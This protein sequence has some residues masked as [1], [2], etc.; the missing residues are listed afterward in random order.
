MEVCTVKS[1]ETDKS[2]L[3]TEGIRDGDII[4][5]L[6]DQ[7]IGHVELK[8]INYL[9]LLQRLRDSSSDVTIHFVGARDCRE[10][11]L[12]YNYK[13]PLARGSDQL[14]AKHKT[15]TGQTLR[16]ASIFQLER[17]SKSIPLADFP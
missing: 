10:G 1:V 9:K 2:P 14:I 3:W 6:S 11:V 13:C 16:Y 12:P 15:A 5:S 7:A 8:D 17:D 4:V